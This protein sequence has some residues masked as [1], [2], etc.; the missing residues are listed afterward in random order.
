[1]IMALI[2]GMGLAMLFIYAL[3]AIAFGSYL[4]PAIVMVAIPFGVAGAI[5]A[6]LVLGMDLTMLSLIGFLALIGVVVNDSLVM[7]DFI[8]RKRRE[9]ADVG[10]AIRESGP[11]RFRPI[12]ITSLT[13]FAGLTPLMLERSLQAQFLIPMAVS[14]AFGVLFATVIILVIVPTTYQVVVDV[15]VAFRRLV[16]SGS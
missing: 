3:L 6:H 9:G 16:R 12:L 2:R 14:L 1:M 11:L 15:K 5:W 8:N 10:E 13:T 4:Q 7:I